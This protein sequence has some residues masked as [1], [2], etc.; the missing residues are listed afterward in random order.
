M[1][2]TV[3]SLKVNTINKQSISKNA[4]SNDYYKNTAEKTKSK[5]KQ[6]EKNSTRQFLGLK[7]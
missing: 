6:A 2:N 5:D 7:K 1:S 4:G 3:I